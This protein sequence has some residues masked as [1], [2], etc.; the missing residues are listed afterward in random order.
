MDCVFAI[1]AAK[2]LKDGQDFGWWLYIRHDDLDPASSKKFLKPQLRHQGK[3]AVLQ[4]KSEMFGEF[5]CS[6]ELPSLATSGMSA[7]RSKL[8]VLPNCRCLWQHG[9]RTTEDTAM[10]CWVIGG[11][12]LSVPCK[13]QAGPAL[14]TL[15]VRT[16]PARSGPGPHLASS[17]PFILQHEEAAQGKFAV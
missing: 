17:T 9:P 6:C 8:T 16:G 14:P 11:G 1:P 3:L 13:D 7:I 5:D 2:D 15:D 4:H 10:P 12:G